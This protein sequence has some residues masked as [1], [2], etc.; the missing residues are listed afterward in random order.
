MKPNK[1]ALFTIAVG[2]DSI[3]S[4]CQNIPCNKKYF[5]QNQ[6][7]DYFLFTNTEKKIKDVVNIPCSSSPWPYT[8]LLKNSSIY[9]YLDKINGWDEY[10][11]VFFIDADFGIGNKYDFFQHDFVL[12]KSCW[13]DKN[14]GGFFYGGKT[15]CFK[16]LCE[17]FYEKIQFH[18]E[19]NLP[20]PCDLDEFYLGLLR[21]RYAEK[22]HL[23][24]MNRQNNTLI[25]HNNETI[26]ERIQKLF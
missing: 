10:T 21:E 18:Y 1:I 16:Q 19:N 26:D 9:N 17:L 8:M 2:K 20:V 3:N 12:V 4:V 13:N 22:N 5:G 25:F 6:D 15:E 7:V 23:I 11:H 14:N 24:E